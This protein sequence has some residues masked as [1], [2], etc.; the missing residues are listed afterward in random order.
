MHNLPLS[1]YNLSYTS[2]KSI[3]YAQLAIMHARF[4]NIHVQLFLHHHVHV[5]VLCQHVHAQLF[6]HQHEV[7]RAHGHAQHILHNISYSG[8]HSKVHAHN[9]YHYLYT[10]Q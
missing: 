6:L 3:M 7:H 5:L 4:A 8:M 10:I 2:M 9:Y 1:I